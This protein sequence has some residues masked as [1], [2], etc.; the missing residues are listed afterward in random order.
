MRCRATALS[1]HHSPATGATPLLIAPAVDITASGPL[2]DP[3]AP[4][5]V[6][7]AVTTGDAGAHRHGRPGRRHWWRWVALGVTLALA[8]AGFV[9]AQ[10]IDRPLARPVLASSLAAS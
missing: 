4:P 3:T 1:T 9:A 5:Q 2:A 7:E 8:A 10:R 6:T